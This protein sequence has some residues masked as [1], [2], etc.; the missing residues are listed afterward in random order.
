MSKF[1]ATNQPTDQGLLL[2]RLHHYVG[3]DFNL[4][5]DIDTAGLTSAIHIQLVKVSRT[6]TRLPNL[7][8]NTSLL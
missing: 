4:G 1:L 8:I 2:N 6:L 7:E 3:A 5:F